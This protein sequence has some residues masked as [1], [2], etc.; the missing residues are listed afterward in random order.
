VAVAVPPGDS[1]GDVHGVVTV[2]R[3]KRVG[4]AA[5]LAGA[6]EYMQGCGGRQFIQRDVPAVGDVSRGLFLTAAD[7]HYHGTGIDG[8]DVIGRYGAH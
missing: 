2:L 7:I 8:G 1:A 4:L 5:A 6:A 3:E